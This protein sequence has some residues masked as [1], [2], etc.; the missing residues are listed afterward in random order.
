MTVPIRARRLLYTAILCIGL[1]LAA[2][3]CGGQNGEQAPDP[4]ASDGTHEEAKAL[5]KQHCVSCH[6]ADLRGRVG[7]ETNISAIGSRLSEAEIADVIANGG[8][9]RMPGFGGRLSAD[10][11]A[12]LSAWLGELN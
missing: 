2:A 11:I 4:L 5:F 10:D 9:N 12:A 8:P 1:A 3:A 7:A 6:G